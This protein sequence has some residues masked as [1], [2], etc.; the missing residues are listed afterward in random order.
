MMRG[1]DVMVNKNSDI[2]LLPVIK[3]YRNL[4]SLLIKEQFDILNKD[5]LKSKLQMKKKEIIAKHKEQHSI[6]QTSDGRWRTKLP[7]ESKPKGKRPIAKVSLK[8]LEDAIVE[9]YTTN[10][11]PDTLEKLYPE[12]LRYK[13]KDTTKANAKKL[14]WVWDKYYDGEAIVNRPLSSL[15]VLLSRRLDGAPSFT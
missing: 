13:A 15:D 14:S 2:T 7:D 12:W 4:R 5:E 8:D 10:R 3:Q 9:W 11:T 6:W 1:G